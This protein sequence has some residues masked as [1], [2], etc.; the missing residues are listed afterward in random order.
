MIY[1]V[2]CHD[3]LG[4]G[5]GAIVER[6]YTPPPSFHIDRLRT[7]PAGRFFAVITEGYGSM[8]SYGAQIPPDD[9]WAIVAYIRALQLS[10]HFPKDEMTP[11][12]RDELNRVA[13]AS[14]PI[15]PTSPPSQGGPPK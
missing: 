10:Q 2:E 15:P 5:R 6:G 8:P 7:S 12:M 11:A 1:C 14:P 9:R 3:A 13:Q 4:T